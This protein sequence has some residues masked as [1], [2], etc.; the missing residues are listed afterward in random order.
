MMVRKKNRWLTYALLTLLVV[1]VL[2]PI[3]WVVSTSFR[4]DEAAFS[5]KLF[6]SRLTLQH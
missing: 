5:P 6:S 3:V 4:R 1:V 2:F